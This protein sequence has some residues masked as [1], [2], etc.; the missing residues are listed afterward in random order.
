MVAAAKKREQPEVQ[1]YA[2]EIGIT[3]SMEKTT[4][5]YAEWSAAAELRLLSSKVVKVKWM[6]NS[7]M[8]KF[9]GRGLPWEVKQKPMC[10]GKKQDYIEGQAW[11]VTSG[12]AFAGDLLGMIAEIL[13]QMMQRRS[14]GRKLDEHPRRKKDGNEGMAG[15]MANAAAPKEKVEKGQEEEREAKKKNRRRD[16]HIHGNRNVPCRRNN[17][18]DN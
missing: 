3:E 11:R 7:Q 2:K 10:C 6:T 8:A 5:Q 12:N 1:D 17:E 14:T 13:V 9:C 4:W 18:S 16:G 15:T